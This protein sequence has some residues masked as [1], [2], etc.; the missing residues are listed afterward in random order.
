MPHITAIAVNVADA[1]RIAVN[2]NNR[3]RSL[4]RQHSINATDGMFNS[5]STSFPKKR[6]VITSTAI[7]DNIDKT[8]IAGAQ[9]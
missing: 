1:I 2:I 4:G 8:I 6:Y 9:K 5:E 7:I 3:I